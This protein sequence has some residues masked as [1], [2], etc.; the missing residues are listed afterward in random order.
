M[1]VRYILWT[2]LLFAIFPASVQA[3]APENEDSHRQA[4]QA[5]IHPSSLRDLL[6]FASLYPHTI[7][8]KASLQQ[9]WKIISGQVSENPPPLP[10][11]FGLT[12]AAL[13]KLI[14]PGIIDQPTAPE[15][16]PETIALIDTIGASLPNRKLKGHTAQTLHEIEDLLPEE[17]DLARALVLLDHNNPG[18]LTAVEAAL[19][20]L[21][22]EL[23]ARIGKDADDESKISALTHL[24]FHDLEIRFPP[25]SEASE[26][27]QQFS[28]L[29]S[30]LFSRRGVCLGA[31]VLYL[32]LAQRIGVPLSIYTPPGHIFVAYNSTSRL[33]VIETTAR[34]IDI[35]IDR[36][37]GLSL[38]SLA[39]R[40]M[41]EV[42]GMVIFNRTAAYLKD[43][44]WDK[45][46][47]SYHKA[48]CFES[49]EEL[50]QMISL[51]EL[52]NG[53]ERSSIQRAR[54]TLSHLPDN[55]LEPDLLLVDL[56]QGTL[57]KKAA[58]TIV[59]FSESEGEQLLKAID[60][61]QQLQ[62]ESSNSLVI[63]FHLAY[64]WLS[65]GKPKEALP[66][67]EQ[68][69]VREN[70]P[71]SIHA[72]LATLYLDRMNITG[73]WK[74]AICAVKKAQQHQCLPRPLYHLILEL[75]MKSPHCTDIS[76]L[77]TSQIVT[78]TTHG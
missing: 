38:K 3:E 4:L 39:E 58:E 71:C 32:T 28:D 12:A 20:V 77:L 60:A 45:A 6:L 33:H 9:A 65:Y 59:E 57:S 44:Q 54:E 1:T 40:T 73:A 19:D 30:V 53:Q 21:A 10:P 27:T 56:A 34:G 17:I 8:G 5:R 46:L 23:V 11:N 29:S 63:P 76:D 75:Q 48:L 22:L 14:Q 78:S 26:K 66:L 16:P 15:L 41:K 51:C 37:L 35:P 72:L 24:L 68:L 62:L 43:K 64:A 25:Q 18:N 67:L 36:Y 31:S 50:L 2:L 42:I 55:R 61:L 47:A 52:L 7:E 49:G 74:E 69:C 70:A 13:I